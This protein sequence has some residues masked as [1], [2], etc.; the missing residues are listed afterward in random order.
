VQ[1]SYPF[2]DEVKKERLIIRPTDDLSKMGFEITLPNEIEEVDYA[3]TWIKSDGSKLESKGKDR[4]GL[5]F[6]DEL[7]EK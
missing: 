6:I 1:I 4:F 2:F 7:P 3:L 5:I